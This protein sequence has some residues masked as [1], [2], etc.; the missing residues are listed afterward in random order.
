M[1]FVCPSSFSY[2][3][4]EEEKIKNKEKKKTTEKKHR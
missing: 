4:K 3:I 1:V 2:G